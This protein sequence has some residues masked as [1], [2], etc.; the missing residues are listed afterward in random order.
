MRLGWPGW[1]QAGAAF[2]LGA[3]LASG[4][5]PLGFWWLA[6]PAL[7]ALVAL[8]GRARAPAQAAWLGLFAGAGH[9]ALALSWL[10]EPFLIDP[11]THAWMAPF[12]V[13]L[14]SF[15]LALFWAAAAA[16]TARLAGW[17]RPLALALALT[18]AEL[19]RGHVLTGFPWALIGHVF[20]DTPMAQMASLLGPTGLTLL[21]TLAAA[22]PVAFGLRGLVA[23]AA[24]LAASAAFGLWRLDQPDPAARPLAL[25]LA[26]PNAEQSLK[27][28]PEQARIYFDRLLTLTAADP[29][30]DLVIW[31]ETAVPYLLDRNPEIPRILADYGRGATLAVG[32]QRLRR[33]ARLQQHGGHRPGCRS[34]G[35]L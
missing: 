20:L 5:V 31:P 8:I 9:F 27:W 18:L 23:G 25:R 34:D 35:D 11:E 22:L 12:A 28:D 16:L 13:L 26:Q 21:A 19:A 14:M 29:R 17:R 10:I 3:V 30:P 32:V 24:L 33:H 6:L 2:G 4:Q 15:G 7:A 1:A